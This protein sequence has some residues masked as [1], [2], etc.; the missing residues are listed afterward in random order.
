[1]HAFLLL[2]KQPISQTAIVGHKTR[3][4]FDRYNIAGSQHIPH[5]YDVGYEGLL[6]TNTH[7]DVE[8]KSAPG[9]VP[10]PHFY[11]LRAK[12]F[13]LTVSSR[14]EAAPPVATRQG[15]A[16]CLKWT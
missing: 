6:L 8:G 3:S 15:L 1:M 11:E 14:N 12:G 2:Q 13:P 5:N 10:T 16:L 4:G 9:I 7:G